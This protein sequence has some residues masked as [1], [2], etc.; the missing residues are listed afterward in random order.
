MAKRPISGASANRKVAGPGGDGKTK[1]MRFMV[2]SENFSAVRTNMSRAEVQ[3]TKKLIEEL[4]RRFQVF[5]QVESLEERAKL[6]REL[7][8]ELDELYLAAVLLGEINPSGAIDELVKKR[9]LFGKIRQ[10]GS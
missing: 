9:N 3:D 7:A 8:A 2:T 1:K 5:S 6:W 4:R 10:K